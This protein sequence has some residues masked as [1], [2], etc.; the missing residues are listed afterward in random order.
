ME[1]CSLCNEKTYNIKDIKEEW[2]ID[3]IKKDH[4]EWVQSSGA[5]PKCIEYY[6]N[7]EDDISV[8]D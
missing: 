3:A 1:N 4:P 5:C 6:S 2:L 8:Q 7:L